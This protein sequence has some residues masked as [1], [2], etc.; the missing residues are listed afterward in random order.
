MCLL[1]CGAISINKSNGNISWRVT[2]K[3]KCCAPLG[4]D[5]V[6]GNF[7]YYFYGAPVVSMHLS[8]HLLEQ[9]FSGVGIY[10]DVC[11]PPMGL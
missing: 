4:S 9:L 8:G 11:A 10:S 5:S 2:K 6:V 3:D 7:H 1:V